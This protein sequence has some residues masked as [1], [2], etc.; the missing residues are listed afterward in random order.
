LHHADAFKRLGL[1]PPKG[2]LL[3]GPPGC[4]KTTLARAA[5]TAS[6]ATVIALS[7]ADVF[8]KYL[9]EGEKVLRSTF[10]KARKSAPAVLLLD[11]IDGMCGSRGDNAS[12]GAHDV[13]TRLLSVFLT[14]MDGLETVP[15]SAGGVL[16][17]ATTNRPES[18]DPALTRPGRLDL[19]LE[20]PP[21][22]LTGRVEALRV[23]TR[24]V[25]L[26]DD[27]DLVA[28]ARAAVGYTGAELRHVVKE[29]ALAAL[30]QDMRATRVRRAHFT[31]ASKA[32]T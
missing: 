17:M 4:A 3:H 26:D 14:E 16:V 30:R 5:A 11:E 7:A 6:G 31:I 24:D 23:H 8:S 19:V 25:T 1:R 15:S 29:A 32:S 9:G 18:L 13:A 27:V 21:L 12:D 20:I 2:I 22:D 28:L 10:A